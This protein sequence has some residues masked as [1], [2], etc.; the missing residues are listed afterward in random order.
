MGDCAARDPRLDVL[1]RR[2]RWAVSVANS[3]GIVG[4]FRGIRYVEGTYL[5]FQLCVEF[6]WVDLGMEPSL[7]KK[8]G[9]VFVPLNGLPW[10]QSFPTVDVSWWNPILPLM[11]R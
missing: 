2:L 3:P 9:V 7:K 11:C 5:V 6:H 8:R 1:S 10:T 4:Y